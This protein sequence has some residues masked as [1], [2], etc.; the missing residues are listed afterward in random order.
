MIRK[1]QQ[2]D[3]DQVISIW[4]EASI[5]AHDFIESAFW[6]SKAKDMREIYIPSGETYVFEE[7]EIIKGFVS[8]YKD[9]IAAIFVSP[10]YQGIGIG[11]QLMTKSKEIREKLNLA[12]YT[13]NHK[14]IEFYKKCGFKIEI[15]QI[16]EH[17]GHY[18]LLMVYPS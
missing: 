9:T 4:L 1:F 6:K 12:V 16:D 14:S 11:T 17:T 15:E 7:E 10:N 5:T 18:E 13:E 2:T 3:I 8:M